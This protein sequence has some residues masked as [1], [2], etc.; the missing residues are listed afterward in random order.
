LKNLIP[1]V[2]I[3][4]PVSERH[5]HLLDE[6]LK[7]LDSLDYENIEV[8]LVDTTPDI[9]EYYKL[10]KTKK[11]KGK[12]IKVFRYA[13][14]YKKWMA[15][16]WMAFA[17]EKIRKYFLDNDFDFLMWLDDDIFLP[18]WGIQRLL[19]YN[20]DNV[21]FYIHV[22]FEPE[23]KPCL[24]KSGEIIM[25]KGLDYYLWEE[26]DAY[27]DFVK[28]FNEGTLNEYEKNL[29]PFIIKDTFH[30][31]LFKTYGVNLGCLMVKREVIEQIPFR[32]HPTF[33]Y[34]EDL[35][36]FAEANE[37]KFEFWVDTNYRCVH[38]NTEWTSLVEKG[39]KKQ[40]GF[41]L[42]FGPTDAEKLVFIQRKQD[43]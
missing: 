5:K 7:S 32:T 18:K 9:D 25:G 22:Y 12:K 39:P 37:K 31:Q 1:K 29:I 15:V 2:L 28:R 3:A 23:T 4:T 19:S 6:W 30:P 43:G 27:K 40:G 13:W 36:Y 21:G 33:I 8:C 17:R 34:G 14:N 26:I 38:K 10:L 41:T 24:L 16:Q 11:V 35:W 42:A 20:K